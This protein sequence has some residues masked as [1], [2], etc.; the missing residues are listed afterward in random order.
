MIK[1]LGIP[2]DI[3]SS[4]LKGP[5]AAPDI[6]RKMDTD[7]SANSFAENGLKVK[8]NDTYNDLG[9]MGINIHDAPQVIHN[10]IVDSVL[11]TLQDN[12]KLLCL[13]GDHSI[14]YPILEAYAKKFS[15]IN[16]LHFDA[17]PDLY[18]NFQDNPYSHASPFARIMENGFAQ[19][20]IQ[21]GIRTLDS[22]QRRQVEKFKVNVF[23]MKDFDAN[24]VIKYVNQMTGPLYISIDMDALDP[25]CA[26]GVSHHEPGGLLTRDILSIIQG[27]DI[28]VIGADIV[29]YN[30]TRD[31]NNMTAMVAY[32]L[33]KE[34]MA[35]MM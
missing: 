8:A 11:L 5:A 22:H 20:L 9:N 24:A 27:I 7:G 3:N 32:K 28:E 16:I 21:V 13:G 12:A 29:E 30:P 23:E 10:N 14:S 26:P 6:I 19:S 25:S 17:H 1:V 15:S 2:S 31:I 4:F 34:V 35:K 18:H 33:F